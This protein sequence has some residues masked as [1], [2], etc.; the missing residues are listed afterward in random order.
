[1]RYHFVKAKRVIYDMYVEADSL[2]EAN[3]LV[4]N[5]PDWDEDYDAEIILYKTWFLLDEEGEEIDSG[6]LYK[7]KNLVQLI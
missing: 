6:I 4:E 5:N 2:E 3:E 7:Y 1:M